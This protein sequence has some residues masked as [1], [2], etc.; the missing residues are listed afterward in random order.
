MH[1]CLEQFQSNFYFIHLLLIWKETLRRILLSLIWMA[2]FFV[3]FTLIDSIPLNAVSVG[4]NS[5]V[6]ISLK[7]FLR[8]F[9]EK[10][11]DSKY[12]HRK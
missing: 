9:R 5:R 1:A 11:L 12:R 7:H 8:I 6:L 2:I 3:C 4:V 10:S